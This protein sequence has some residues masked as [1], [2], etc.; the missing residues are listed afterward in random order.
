MSTSRDLAIGL[1]AT[2]GVDTSIIL[3]Y[4][5]GLQD[6]GL[7]SSGMAPVG[8]DEA[9]NLILSLAAD[10][11]EGGAESARQYG[12][13]PFSVLFHTSPGGESISR[14]DADE[15]APKDIACCETFRV[16]MR[17]MIA[18]Y[19][20]IDCESLP[21]FTPVDINLQ[22]SIDGE[23]TGMV[24]GGVCDALGQ[25]QRTG[26]Y[27]FGCG[28]E[29]PAL[30]FTTTVSATVLPLLARMTPADDSGAVEHRTGRPTDNSEEKSDG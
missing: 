10:N 22:R 19:R 26:Q 17:H 14:T 2:L 21:T 18:G 12:D 23:R 7:L 16:A 1:A 15:L 13:L 29:P 5:R 27:W 30:Q 25:P 28:D 9:I 20:R 8:L 4:A 3:A 6:E 24:Y 11:P